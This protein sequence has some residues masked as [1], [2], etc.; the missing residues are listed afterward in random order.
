MKQ[1]DIE[2]LADLINEQIAKG[3]VREVLR[4]QMAASASA[5]IPKFLHPP[6]RAKAAIEIA[7]LILKEIG[8]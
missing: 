1:G 4:A 5:G 8:L 3:P 2:Y 6:D 7:D